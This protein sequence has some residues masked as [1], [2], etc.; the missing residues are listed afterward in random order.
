M[1][2]EEHNT[3]KL[4]GEILQMT[5]AIPKN[6]RLVQSQDGHGFYGDTFEVAIKNLLGYAELVSRGRSFDLIVKGKRYEV[7]TGAGELGRVGT[8]AC[9]G[10]SRV[11]YCPVYAE[12]KPLDEQEAF[13]LERD[14]FIQVLE[15]VGLY[16]SEK[17][18]TNGRSQVQAIQ[19][20]WNR[21]KNAPHGKKYF[22]LIDA[23]Y[24]N[25]LMDWEDFL[26]ELVE[27]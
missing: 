10:V 17:T 12:D 15:E 25:T 3:S 14:T 18:P 6:R 27:G 8:K 1:T 11:I 22:A 13:V 26:N 4:K 19:T 5:H 23:L 2:V 9:A 21:S 20:F 24:E 7:K 16:R